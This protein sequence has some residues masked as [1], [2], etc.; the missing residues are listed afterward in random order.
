MRAPRG[1]WPGLAPVLLLAAGCGDRFGFRGYQPDATA[2]PESA[3]VMADYADPRPTQEPD[4]RQLALA[5]NGRL[6]APQPVHEHLPGG[7]EKPWTGPP[8]TAPEAWKP[9]PEQPSSPSPASAVAPLAPTA[10]ASTA[11]RPAAGEG[12][13]VGETVDVFVERHPEFSGRWRVGS[14]GYLAIPVGGAFG[15]EMLSPGG[16]SRSV[17]R[18]AGL[19]TEGLASGIARELKPYLNRPP[20]VRVTAGPPGGR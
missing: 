18:A 7:V 16:F 15:P 10:P 19:D 9:L 2:T 13:A 14:D 4:D 20:E 5:L 8:R 17:G 3:V 6:R 12:L 11:A 1:I